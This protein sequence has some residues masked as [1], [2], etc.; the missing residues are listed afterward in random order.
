MLAAAAVGALAAPFV[1]VARADIGPRRP[2]TRREVSDPQSRLAMRDETVTVTIDKTR[3]AHVEARFHF[4]LVEPAYRQTLAMRLGFPELFEDAP[5][6]GFAVRQSVYL[7]EGQ[8][9]V[10]TPVRDISIEGPDGTGVPEKA[11]WKSWPLVFEGHEGAPTEEDV[12][13]VVTYTQKLT[14]LPDRTW[15]YR[16]VLRSG[17]PW[18]DPIGAAEIRVTLAKGK[19]VSASPAGATVQGNVITWS[20]KNLEPTQDVVVIIR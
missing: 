13:A 16:Y 8:P 1:P 4:A 7:R 19:V 17:A 6:E 12:A 18:R 14:R 11:K 15:R 3:V 10:L 2:I 20:L 9:D 5:L